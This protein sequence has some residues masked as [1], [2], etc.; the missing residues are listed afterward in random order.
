MRVDPIPQ[1]LCTELRLPLM[2][3]NSCILYI[4]MK[5]VTTSTI[6]TCRFSP[7]PSDPGSSAS[8]LAGR[9]SPAPGHIDRVSPKDGDFLRHIKAYGID[10]HRLYSIAWTFFH[11]KFLS[12]P[13]TRKFPVSFRWWLLPWTDQ[14]HKGLSK[15]HTSVHGSQRK[16]VYK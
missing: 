9:M 3:H 12:V 13:T 11:Q 1:A 16:L 14:M 2:Y 8:G 4:C 15:C 6:R 7:E 5:Y 10:M